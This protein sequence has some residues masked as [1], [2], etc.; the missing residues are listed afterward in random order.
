MLLNNKLS[1]QRQIGKC[2]GSTCGLIYIV[3]VAGTSTPWG[4]FSTR[5]GKKRF[6][7]GFNEHVFL[8]AKDLSCTTNNTTIL[9]TIHVTPPHQKKNF[10][11]QEQNFGAAEASEPR[12][13]TAVEKPLKIKYRMLLSQTK[14]SLNKLGL[15]LEV[16]TKKCIIN[17]N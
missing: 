8:Q 4:P 13:P 11:Q 10:D 6:K 16:E 15:V 14:E 3:W 7:R 12:P 2:L 9:N 1:I 5:Q 17:Q